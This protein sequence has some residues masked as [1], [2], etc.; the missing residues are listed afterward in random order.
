MHVCS[1][2]EIT[3]QHHDTGRLYLCPAAEELY[4][5]NNFEF[6][7]YASMAIKIRPNYDHFK[8]R[9][10]VQKEMSNFWIAREEMESTFDLGIIGSS[11]II[12]KP[13]WI[14]KYQLEYGK[15]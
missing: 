5:H 1:P 15:V 7:P 6:Y 13:V 14:G 9:T 10:I 11:P 2:E 12:K 3:Q 4:L 8:D